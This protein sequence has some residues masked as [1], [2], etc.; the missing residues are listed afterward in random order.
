M[1]YVCSSQQ[2]PSIPILHNVELRL[3]MPSDHL[4]PNSIQSLDSLWLSRGLSYSHSN[5]RPGLQRVLFTTRWVVGESPDSIVTHTSLVRRSYEGRGLPLHLSTL[6][7]LKSALRGR[8]LCW[9]D[10]HPQ[11]QAVRGKGF[12]K[13]V[14]T[15]GILLKEEFLS[16][17]TDSSRLRI[18]QLWAG[19]VC[20]LH[21]TLRSIFFF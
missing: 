9:E 18:P 4:L 1:G 2:A 7:S 5:H 6:G 13:S 19:A 11:H 21:Y 14:S 16:R 20:H 17:A 15:F 12:D 3:K 8:C 10:L